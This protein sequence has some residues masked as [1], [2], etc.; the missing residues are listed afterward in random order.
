MN[1]HIC[2]VA[3]DSFCLKPALSVQTRVIFYNVMKPQDENCSKNATE[4]GKI[5][6]KRERYYDRL[7]VKLK[8]K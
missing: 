6:K 8:K 1:G 5:N 2:V 3:Y 4:M 7:G